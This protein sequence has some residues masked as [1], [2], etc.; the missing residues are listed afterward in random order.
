MTKIT[1]GSSY[2]FVQGGHTYDNN[3][4]EITEKFG[5]YFIGKASSVRYLFDSEGKCL[6]TNTG[7]YLT[8]FTLLLT[9]PKVISWRYLYLNGET[10]APSQY[11]KP[12]AASYT[13]NARFIVNVDIEPSVIMTRNE[14]LKLFAANG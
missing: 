13:P 14:L 9:T 10:G 3:T 7:G 1:V 4:I 5:D 6:G 11:V 12:I 2:G 8:P